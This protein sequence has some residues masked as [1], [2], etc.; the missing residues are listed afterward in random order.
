M[1]VH[2]L[3]ARADELMAQF[4]RMRSG[5]GDLQQQLRA[6][7]ATVTSDDGLVTVTV[8]PRGQVTKVELDP[9]IYRRPNAAQLSTTVTET[10]RAATAQAMAEVEQ[11]CRPLV[12]DAQFQAHMDFDLEGIFRQLDTDLPG[13]DRK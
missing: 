11:I 13:G 6:V 3:R 8:G 10:I 1:D 12:P 4:D 7:S 9:R 2:G 5:V